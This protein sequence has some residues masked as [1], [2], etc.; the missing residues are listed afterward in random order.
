MRG[1]DCNVKLSY[2]LA[3]QF[4]ADGYDFVIRY[5][6]RLMKSS[7][8]IDKTELDNI[9]RAGLK[10]GLVQHCPPSPG[11]FPSRETGALWGKNGAIFAKEAGYK[12]GC[13]LYLDLEDVN[14][15][16]RNR[17]QT[18]ID[19]CNAWY[20]A[21][22]GYTPGIYIGF[23]TWLTGD[24]LY[25]KLKFKDYWKSMSKVPDVSVRGYAMIQKPQIKANGIYI[26]PDEVTGDRMG[27]F[28]VFM[29]SGRMLTH[30]IKVYSDGTCEMEKAL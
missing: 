15:D 25:H 23:N 22:E 26:D 4:K 27:R 2:E 17:Q 19:F 9:L 3:K 7:N 20:D 11:I 28:P 8:D 10:L 13:I 18:I 12:E 21:C 14:T 1:F 16:Y 30:T 29:E 5:V 6:G 24:Q